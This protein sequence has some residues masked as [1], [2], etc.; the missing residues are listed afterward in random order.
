MTPGLE[1]G[2]MDDPSW[3]ERLRRGD[4]PAGRGVQRPGN[5]ERGL[6]GE[7]ALLKSRA[8]DRAWNS[9]CRQNL[10]VGCSGSDESED[11][12][13][14][15]LYRGKSLRFRQGAVIARAAL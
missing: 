7:H 11:A 2:V 6:H 13:T 12:L 9:D 4:Q 1:A 3:G 15:D 5:A 8:W 14:V 10:T